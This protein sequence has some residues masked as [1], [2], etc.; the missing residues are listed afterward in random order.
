[1]GNSWYVPLVDI[2]EAEGKAKEIFTEI[3][4]TEGKPNILHLCF[5]N[6]ADVLDAEWRL[7]NTLFHA[8]S[9]LSKKTRQYVSLTV[10]MLH[11]CPG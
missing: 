10:S 2:P 7:E 6:D 4:N 5:A 11:G 8:D 3:S 9:T 1:M